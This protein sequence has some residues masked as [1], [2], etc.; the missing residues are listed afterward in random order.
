MTINVYFYCLQHNVTLKTN[1]FI[2]LYLLSSSYKSVAVR[3]GKEFIV[4][5]LL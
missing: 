5:E 1:H 4:M 3:G 2:S